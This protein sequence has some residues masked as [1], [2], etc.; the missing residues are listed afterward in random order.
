MSKRF[1]TAGFVVA[2]TTFV[3]VTYDVGVSAN[4]KWGNK[5]WERSMNPVPLTLYTNFAGS[6]QSYF[7]A[8]LS[9]IG[10]RV[11]CSP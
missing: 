9:L 1:I 10:M 6:W 7:T 3:A 8:A 4:N 5:H 2:V 11:Q